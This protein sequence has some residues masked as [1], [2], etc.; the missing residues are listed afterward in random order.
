MRMMNEKV[1]AERDVWSDV[2]IASKSN[3]R[4]RNLGSQDKANNKS[5]H[6][7]KYKSL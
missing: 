1:D 2:K 6:T 5:I 7:K 4:G 3:K